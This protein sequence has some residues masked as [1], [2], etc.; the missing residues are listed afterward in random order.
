MIRARKV[1]MLTGRNSC[2]YAADGRYFGMGT[3]NWDVECLE[4][5]ETLTVGSH[6]VKDAKEAKAYFGHKC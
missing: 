1:R 4:C 2:C 5:G 3:V 6:R